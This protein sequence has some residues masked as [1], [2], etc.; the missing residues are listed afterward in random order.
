[1]S[2]VD[3]NAVHVEDCVDL[4]RDVGAAGLDAVSLFQGI[5]VIGPDPSEV[6]NVFVLL[7]CAEVD[8][9]DEQVRLSS[10]GLD[11]S[12]FFDS[13]DVANQHFLHA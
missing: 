13:L 9:L 8:A 2:V 10:S 1:V 6:A 5:R 4:L 12:A 11:E 3:C 7:E